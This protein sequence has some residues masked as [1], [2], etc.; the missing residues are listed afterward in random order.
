MSDKNFVFYEN[1]FMHQQKVIVNRNFYDCK[2]D[3]PSKQGIIKCQ[4]VLIINPYFL[5]IIFNLK[6]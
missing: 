6:N 3:I 2:N 4:I 5:I 1:K